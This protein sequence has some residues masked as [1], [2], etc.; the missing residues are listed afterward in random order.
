V[1]AGAALVPTSRDQKEE[2][3]EPPAVPNTEAGPSRSRYM[4]SSGEQGRQTDWRNSFT[5]HSNLKH[6][7]N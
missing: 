1:Q 2:E 3:Q 5:S 4:N 6:F 7:S